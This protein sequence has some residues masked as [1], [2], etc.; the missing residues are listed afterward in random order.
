MEVNKKDIIEKEYIIL[1]WNVIKYLKRPRENKKQLDTDCIHIVNSIR[2]KYEFPYC[3]AHLRDLARSYSEA[4]I[5]RVN[6]DL[7]FLQ[8]V[9]Q[10][11]VI[12]TDGE[13][14]FL[15]KKPPFE[16]FMDIMNER[17]EDIS[18]SALDMPC[19]IH[20]VDMTRLSDNHPMR[21][22]LETTSGICGPGILSKWINDLYYKIFDEVY[23]YKNIRDYFLQMKKDIENNTQNL[24]PSE[25]RYKDFLIDRMMPF[26]ESMSINSEE[27]LEKI[28]KTNIELWLSINH[29]GDIPEGT[30]VTCA[31]NMLDVH[32]LFKEKLKKDKNTLSNILRD[33]KIV[34]YATRSKYFVTEDK[35]CE[36]KAKFVLKALG[37]KTKVI[38]LDG[39]RE[40]FS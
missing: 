14:F 11:V 6:D 10:D 27:E 29:N 13:S 9:S 21:E 33:S 19:G 24:S 30:L 2:K 26:F 38:S 36:K 20:T 39:F 28:W 37:Y 25:I 17:T 16:L 40:R 32:P 15:T 34:Y 1:D 3:E 31:Y 35:G 23:D 5:D 12:G 4:N 22:M 7:K 8:Q 18:V